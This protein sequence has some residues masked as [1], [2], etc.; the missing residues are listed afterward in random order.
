MADPARRPPNALRNQPEKCSP[1]PRNNAVGLGTARFELVW[2]SSDSAQKFVAFRCIFRFGQH[3]LV[4]Y[5]VY[6]KAFS[7]DAAHR[8]DPHPR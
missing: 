5:D 8:H 4:T 7:C 2:A 3:P 6:E 1:S